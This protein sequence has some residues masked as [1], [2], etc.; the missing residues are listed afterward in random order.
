MAIGFLG[1]VLPYGQMSLWG[2]ETSPTCLLYQFTKLQ[3]FIITVNNMNIIIILKRS[4]LFIANYRGKI[5]LADSFFNFKNNRPSSHKRKGGKHKI[6]AGGINRIGPHNSDL[7]SIIFGSLL[8][9]ATAEILGLLEGTRIN[10]YQESTHLT[11]I[12]WLQ[13]FLATRGYCNILLPKIKTRLV[14]G[15]KVRKCIR[16]HT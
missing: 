1:Y 2:Y 10:F 4:I 8:G 12:Y 16:I 11:H 14:K 5:K 7:L 13:N 9:N 3:C 15:G 6:A